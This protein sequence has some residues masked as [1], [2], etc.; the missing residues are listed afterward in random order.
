[1]FLL[2]YISTKNADSKLYKPINSY[3]SRLA[4]T[5][6]D[7]ADASHSKSAKS[8]TTTILYGIF[9]SENSYPCA[10]T[11]YTDFT[12]F[13]RSVIVPFFFPLYDI[14]VKMREKRKSSHE[15]GRL[16]QR[17]KNMTY[18]EIKKNEEVLAY[19]KKGNDNLGTMGF[20]DHSDAHCA[21]VAERAAMILKTFGYS[22][23]D[24]ELV[25]IAGFMHDMGNA[26]NRHAHAEYGALLAS[27]I[28][29]K[30][31]LPITDRAIIVSAIGNH[32]E[33]TGGAVDPIS[34]ALIIADKTDVRRN[35][36]RQK[37]MASFD[38]HDRVNYAVTEAKLKVNEEKKVITLNLKIDEN[39]C[40][41]LEYFEIFLQRM[42]MC[43]RACEML[44]AKFK[45]T[46]NG[47][48]IV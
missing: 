25:K 35:R 41:M 30:T 40:S 4:Q 39:I 24:I 7:F 14:E 47:S 26:I 19:L 37:E 15:L 36:V 18:K 5:V 13:Y 34:A 46:A 1:M 31:D 22:D 8:T 17:K 12:F 43:R 33:S 20:T 16:R 42:L 10:V 3:C 2:G 29:E 21:M 27:Q 48:K 6:T 11:F 32:D 23:H 9:S 38:I 28:L 45:M 44:G